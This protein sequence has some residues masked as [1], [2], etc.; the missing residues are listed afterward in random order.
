MFTS[1]SYSYEFVDP[2][3]YCSYEKLTECLNLTENI[4]IQATEKANVFCS[5]K[6][7][8]EEKD[9]EET[10][11]IIQQ[12]GICA[13]DQFLVFSSINKH[14]FEACGSHYIEFNKTLVEFI[15]KEQ[16]ERDKRFFEE[17]DPLHNYYKNKSDKALK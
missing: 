15:L 13:F 9:F 8:L 16:I 1:T 14:Q 7:K 12:V 11:L 3:H 6:Y 5:E 17:D 2:P 10:K 4:C